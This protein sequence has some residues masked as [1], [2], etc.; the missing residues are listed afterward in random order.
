MASL[1]QLISPLESGIEPM[2]S[3]VAANIALVTTGASSGKACSPRS[4]ERLSLRIKCTS[5]SAV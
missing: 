2:R 1:S 5:I 4:E 3:P